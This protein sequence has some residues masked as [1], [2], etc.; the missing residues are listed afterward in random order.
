MYNGPLVY[1]YFE[2]NE[3]L[4]GVARLDLDKNPSREGQISIKM[5]LVPT[6]HMV[7]HILHY[8]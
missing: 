1:V 6:L 3:T 8:Y 2:K 7:S 5:E 4:D